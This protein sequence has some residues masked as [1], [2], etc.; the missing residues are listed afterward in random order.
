MLTFMLCDATVSAVYPLFCCLGLRS[1][2]QG[3]HK[4]PW[5]GVTRLYL[6]CRSLQIFLCLSCKLK[7]SV[8][9]ILVFCASKYFNVEEYLLYCIACPLAFASVYYRRSTFSR[10]VKKNQT[11]IQV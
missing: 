6:A 4:L 8:F 1:S 9:I 11:K 5:E 10:D 7:F 3:P 2:G